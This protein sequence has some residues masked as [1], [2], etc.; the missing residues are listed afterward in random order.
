MCAEQLTICA[1]LSQIEDNY[2]LLEHQGMIEHAFMDETEGRRQLLKDADERSFAAPQGGVFRSTA[3][4]SVH[5]LPEGH[6][7]LA[8]THPVEAVVT[9]V[10]TGKD[11]TVRCKYLFGNDGARSQVRKCIAGGEAGDGEW[12]GAIQMEGEA[13]DI[14]W[15]VVRAHVFLSRFLPQR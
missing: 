8:K 5:T 11:H 2:T 9:D 10:A 3:F 15:G 12:K 1:L 13:T 4:K 14:V 6:D 7:E